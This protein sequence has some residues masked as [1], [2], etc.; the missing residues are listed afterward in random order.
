VSAL[1]E[2]FVDD[3]PVLG[4]EELELVLA[5]NADRVY[6]LSSP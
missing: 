3:K 2:P 5:G 4:D 1:A 6:G